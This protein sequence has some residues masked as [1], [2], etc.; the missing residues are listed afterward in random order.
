M[1][2]PLKRG[3]LAAVVMGV[4]GTA[5]AAE[6]E[7]EAQKFSYSI[8]LQ[9]GENLKT[10]QEEYGLPVDAESVLTG[11]RDAMAGT[12]PAISPEEATAVQQAVSARMQ[13]QA[14]AKRQ[15]EVTENQ[16]A[17]EAFLAENRGKDGVQVTES[18]LQYKVEEMGD[19]A[20][21]AATDTVT[22]HY[23]GTLLNGEEFDSS[24][25]RGEPATFQLNRVI[26]GWTEGLQLMPVGS[27][28]TFYIPSD[29]AYGERGAGQMIGPNSTLIFDV[30]L[31]D[32]QAAAE[33]QS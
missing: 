24:Y 9:F 12:E 1:K 32:I 27:K 20:R 21:P 25:Q 8:G 16:Q 33:E 30:E 15:A 3:V 26:P 5:A 17:G 7:T 11:I 19:G 22:V 18:G 29:L 13:E 10:Q 6:L 23:R 28:F 31:L 14:A 2:F 4:A